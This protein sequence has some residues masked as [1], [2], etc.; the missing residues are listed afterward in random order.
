MQ[1]SQ[2]SSS[3]R[4]AEL[5]SGAESAGAGPLASPIGKP[6]VLFPTLGASPLSGARL[7]TEFSLCFKKLNKKDPITKTKVV[8]DYDTAW[9]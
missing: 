5:L 1:L 6:L 8:Y 4:S 9:T 2:P 3:G 7:T